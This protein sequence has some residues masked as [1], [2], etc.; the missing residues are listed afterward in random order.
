MKTAQTELKSTLQDDRIY[1]C[2]ERDGE[3]RG[4]KSVTTKH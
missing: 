1:C 2:A 4:R 3:G